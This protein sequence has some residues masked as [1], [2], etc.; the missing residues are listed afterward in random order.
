MKLNHFAVHLKLTQY[1]KSTILQTKSAEGND[2][3]WLLLVDAVRRGLRT[4]DPET[5]FDELYSLRSSGHL[6]PG[7]RSAR[8]Q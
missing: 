5:A 7:P 1:C 4:A 3:L 8:R 2:Q 6:T